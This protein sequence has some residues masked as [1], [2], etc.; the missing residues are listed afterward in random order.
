[1]Q[2]FVNFKLS[3]GNY[4]KDTDGN[5]ILDMN[6]AQAGLILGYNS[7]DLVNARMTEL[8]DRFVTHKVDANSLPTTDYADLLREMV[9][10]CAPK[11]M[12]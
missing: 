2:R 3:K 4:F 6:A 7:D 8:Y 5:S 10:P 1:M 12:N 9:M 11:G